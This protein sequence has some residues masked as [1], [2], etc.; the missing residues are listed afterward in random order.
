MH[1]SILV[2]DD[3]KAFLLA[4]ER[5]FHKMGTSIDVVESREEAEACL[6]CRPYDVVITDLRLTGVN[7]EEGFDIIRKAKEMNPDTKCVMLSG[8]GDSRI[9]ERALAQ[10]ASFFFEKPVSASQLCRF[11]TQLEAHC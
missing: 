11:V 3:E 10:G 8:S 7:G 5:I 2:V 1:K 9:E 4:V 6:A